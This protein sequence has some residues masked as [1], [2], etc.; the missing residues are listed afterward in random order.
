MTISVGSASMVVGATK[1]HGTCRDPSSRTHM[2]KT[3]VMMTK[4]TMAGTTAKITVRKEEEP[5]AV[6]GTAWNGK[7]EG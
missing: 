2:T 3:A 4:M 6:H 5:L 1:A 7:V